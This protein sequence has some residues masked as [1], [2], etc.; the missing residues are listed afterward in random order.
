MKVLAI[1]IKTYIAEDDL[2]QFLNG[3]I[4]ILTED[5]IFR[6]GQ[7]YYVIAEYYNKKYFK[8]VENVS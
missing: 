5:S 6:K 2:D 3:E 1:C 4:R 7:E 8:L